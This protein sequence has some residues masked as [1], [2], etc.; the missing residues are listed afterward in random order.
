[1]DDLRIYML[2]NDLRNNYRQPVRTTRIQRPAEKQPRSWRGRSGMS[3]RPPS[4]TGGAPASGSSGS[5]GR[6]SASGAPDEGTHRLIQGSAEK[7]AEAIK[8]RE[9]TPEEREQGR[10]M[11]AEKGLADNLILGYHRPLDAG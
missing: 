8:E 4:C 7:G 1:M 11:N 9:W 10:Q 6:P 5:G 3:P 2:C